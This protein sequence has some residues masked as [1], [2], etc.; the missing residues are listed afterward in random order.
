[1]TEN[2]APKTEESNDELTEELIKLPNVPNTEAKE[3]NNEKDHIVELIR[4]IN[5]L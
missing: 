4:V 1:M 5:R 2:S 3:S